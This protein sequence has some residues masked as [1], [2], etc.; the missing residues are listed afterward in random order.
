MIADHIDI[1]KCLSSF[2]DKIS[3]D[4][5]SHTNPG[6]QF[7]WIFPHE[8]IIFIPVLLIQSFFR[9]NWRENI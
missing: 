5:F 7:H 4:F 6:K 2:N 9:K 3:R 1:K 8:D